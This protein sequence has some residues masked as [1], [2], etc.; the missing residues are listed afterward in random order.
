MR[1][2]HFENP[3]ARGT[4]FTVVTLAATLLMTGGANAACPAGLVLSGNKCVPKTEHVEK[5]T[6]HVEKQTQ[7]V[8]KIEHVQKTEPGWHQCPAGFKYIVNACVRE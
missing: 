3:L 7:P 1:V 4:L 2:C 8:Q 6:V 5:K